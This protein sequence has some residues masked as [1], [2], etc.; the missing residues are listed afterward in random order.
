MLN[1][2]NTLRRIPGVWTREDNDAS[3]RVSGR[4]DVSLVQ[5]GG[6]YHKA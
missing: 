1:L 3:A 2:R 6:G 4:S 5:G